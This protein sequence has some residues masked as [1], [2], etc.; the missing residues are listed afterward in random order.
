MP[1]DETTA[2]PRDARK[3]EATKTPGVYRRHAEGCERKRGCTCPYVARWRS[4]GKDCKQLFPTYEQAREHKRKVS[5]RGPRPTRARSTKTVAEYWAEWLPEYR[6]RTARG[7]TSSTRREYAGSFQHHI[8]PYP[9]ARIRMR[10]L[11]PPDVAEWCSELEAAGASPRS[12]KHAKIALGLM[13]ACAV[14]YGDADANP[15]RTVAY[16][17]SEA[18]RERHAPRERLNLT[19]AHVVAILD[20]MP[21]EWAAFFWLIAHTGVRIG[22]LLGLTWRNVH[23]GDDPHIEIVEQVYRGQRKAPKWGSTGKV[24]LSAGMAAWL[25]ELRPADWQTAP[26]RPVFPSRTGQP[27]SYAN[28]YNRVLRPALIRSGVAVKTGEKEIRRRGGKV[29]KVPVYDYR[30]VAFHAFRHAAASLLFDNDRK[31]TEV[32]SWLRHKKL[33]TTV[34]VYIKPVSDSSG[35]AAVMDRI[36][37]VRGH[38]GATQGPETAADEAVAGEPEVAS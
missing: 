4:G 28:V 7:L 13:F 37:P 24:P 16:V 32:Q 36:L 14:E 34:G 15:V 30:G 18:A 10:D 25:T 8:A 35:G 2:R 3:L 11:T 27:L 19:A 12:I 23:L 6:G 31:A 22:E 29:E 21:D 33:T 26:D 20:A 38:V 1:T 5:G 17:P 9:I